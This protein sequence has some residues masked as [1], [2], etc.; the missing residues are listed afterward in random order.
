MK[1][2]QFRDV[3]EKFAALHS[4]NADAQK[5]KALSRLA[6]QLQPFDRKTVKMFVKQHQKNATRDT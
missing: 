5:S 2:S 6:E 3:L 1:I 4:G